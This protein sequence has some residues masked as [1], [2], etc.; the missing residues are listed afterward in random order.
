MSRREL[1]AIRKRI[2]SW[3][4]IADDPKNEP[5][6]RLRASREARLLEDRLEDRQDDQPA[7][8]GTEPVPDIELERRK[9]AEVTPKDRPRALFGLATLMCR[10][11]PPEGMDNLALSLE[12]RMALDAAKQTLTAAKRMGDE[13]KA[14]KHLSEQ[15]LNA[16]VDALPEMTEEEFDEFMESL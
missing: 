14:I 9:V 6:L 10:A 4:Q 7:L 8:S 16:A 13:A 11:H 15:K 3:L 1:Q 12:G 5:D 2:S